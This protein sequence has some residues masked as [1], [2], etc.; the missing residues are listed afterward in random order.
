MTYLLSTLALLCAPVIYAT[1]DRFQGSRD[2]LEGFVLITITGI[3]C[4]HIVP[5]AWRL[6]GTP[7][8]FFLVLGLAFPL[9]L[10]RVYRRALA[11]A[12]LLVLVLAAA[13]LVVHA[14]LDGIALLPAVAGESVLDNGLA[15]G[16]I[17]HRLPVGVA[18]WWVLR[19]R[20]GVAV[21]VAVLLAIVLATGISYFFFGAGLL[22]GDLTSLA[23]FQSFVAG[24]LVHVALFGAGHDE[25]HD[26]DHDHAADEGPHLAG[27]GFR[28]RLRS[29]PFWMGTGMGLVAVGLLPHIPAS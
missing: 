10:E 5:E 15:L 18:V 29:R 27:A 1:L 4:L 23:F 20:F 28:R 2:V 9:L 16:V 12:H 7:S 14:T 26:S 17:L 11:R 21:A 24:S 13:S 6:G 19:P 25:A 22:S 8:L 3:V